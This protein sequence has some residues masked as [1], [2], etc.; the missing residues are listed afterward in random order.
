MKCPHCQHHFA[1]TW[2]RYLQAPLGKHQCPSC[3]GESK[4]SLSRTYLIKSITP[5][6]I[7]AA[8][9][10]KITTVFFIN[11]IPAALLAIF[12]SLLLG[13]PWDKHCDSSRELKPLKK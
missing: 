13:I 3:R 7:P 11:T 12:V 4:L 10:A 9:S 1:L 6:L 2:A 5:I 8:L